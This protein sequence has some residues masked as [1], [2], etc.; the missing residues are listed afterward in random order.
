M[1]KDDQF[2]PMY[3]DVLKNEKLRHLLNKNRLAKELYLE[4]RLYIC[5]GKNSYSDTLGLYDHYLK[6]RLVSSISI[7]D[8]AKTFEAG[9]KT[10]VNTIKYLE[11]IKLIRCIKST[12][13]TSNDRLPQ[14]I[15]VLG[16]HNHGEGSINKDDP[17][18]ELYF[19]SL[20]YGKFS[21]N[22]ETS[23]VDNVVQFPR[24]GTI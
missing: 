24:H 6:G 21:E 19:D 4:L 13:K 20:Y 11:E 12:R 18:T 16:K 7:R 1:A 9:T 23:V 5:R 15:Y 17:Y 2:I 22:N 10:I 8:L 3:F 14:T